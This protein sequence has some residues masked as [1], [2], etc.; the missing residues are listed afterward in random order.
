MVDK[1]NS[2]SKVVGLVAAARFDSRLDEP[3]EVAPNVAGP[4]PVHLCW[5]TFARSKC[6]EIGGAEVVQR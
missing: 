3:E 1:R 6:L 5:G 2:H 4:A